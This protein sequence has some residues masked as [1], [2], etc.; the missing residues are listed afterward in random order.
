MKFQELLCNRG[1]GTSQIKWKQQVEEEFAST[2][3]HKIDRAYK[4]FERMEKY[5]H[6]GLTVDQ[7][8]TNQTAIKY[9]LCYWGKLVRSFH[10]QNRI[11]PILD[12]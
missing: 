10:N 8:S 3:G 2:R 7:G 6:T 4:E 9:L 12:L 5:D 1:R 11:T